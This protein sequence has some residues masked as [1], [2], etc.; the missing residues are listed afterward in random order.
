MTAGLQPELDDLA[1]RLWPGAS[2]ATPSSEGGVV[3]VTG[4]KVQGSGFE[5][6]APHS[7]EGGDLEP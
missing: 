7:P 4:F 5:V 6:H 3:I 2:A 1:T